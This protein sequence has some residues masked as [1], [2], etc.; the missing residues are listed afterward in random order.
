[1]L[2]VSLRPVYGQAMS[3]ESSEGTAG[4]EP[5]STKAVA[6]LLGVSYWTARRLLHGG[7]IAGWRVGVQHRT[8]REAVEAYRTANSNQ[9]VAA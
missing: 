8:T 3:T 2:T 7:S 9:P 4:S 1:M 6:A 5:L